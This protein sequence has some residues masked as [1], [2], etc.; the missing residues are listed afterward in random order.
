MAPGDA[1]EVLLRLG[2]V[3]RVPPGEA[4]DDHDLRR[5][6]VP[7]LE[8]GRLV[9]ILAVRKRSAVLVRQSLESLDRMAK[10]SDQDLFVTPHSFGV[11]RCQ[12]GPGLQQ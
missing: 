6:T 2:T 8:V 11:S 10:G 4:V 1:R 9:P 7:T 12:S 5:D 3:L